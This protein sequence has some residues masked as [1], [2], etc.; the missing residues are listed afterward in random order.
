MK[1]PGIRT[2]KNYSQH[3]Y[4][5]DVTKNIVIL[6]NKQTLLLLIITTSMFRCIAFSCK[7]EIL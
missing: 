2:T 3:L 7:Y 5:L 1:D 6:E 4:C